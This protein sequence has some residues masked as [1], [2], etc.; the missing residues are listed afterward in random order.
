MVP[1]LNL[2]PVT[3]TKVTVLTTFLVK[4]SIV[5]ILDDVDIRLRCRCWF[6]H[7]F[8]VKVLNSTVSTVQE[9]QSKVGTTQINNF[10]AA[11]Y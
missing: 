11:P 5:F 2:N 7:V 4:F 3:V 8:G 1:A 6:L 9:T 10:L